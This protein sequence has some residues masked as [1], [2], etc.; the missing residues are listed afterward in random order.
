MGGPDSS[1]GI[2]SSGVAAPSTC[3][4]LHPAER[5]AI[6]GAEPCDRPTVVVMESGS[7][8]R[9]LEWAIEPVAAGIPVEVQIDSPSD[10]Y[11]EI[12]GVE[13]PE[14]ELIITI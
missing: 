5:S 14:V 6:V 8:K 7:S 3:S 13:E 10:L 2:A 12:L 4:I 1:G 11:F 9:T